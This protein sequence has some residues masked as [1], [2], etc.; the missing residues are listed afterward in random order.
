VFVKHVARANV[1][2]SSVAIPGPTDLDAPA[3]NVATSKQRSVLELAK[4][5]GEVMQQ[6]PTLEF[7]PPRAG[8]LSRSALD[9]SKAKRVLG[10]APQ[11]AFDDGLGE[12]VNWF[13]EEAK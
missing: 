11:Y 10:W 13:K 9:V 7:A 6:K 8:E 3:F 1:L 4:S 5:V 12:L 2:A